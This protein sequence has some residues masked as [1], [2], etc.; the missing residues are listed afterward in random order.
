MWGNCSVSW[1]WKV[2]K[3]EKR[4]LMIQDME[5]EHTSQGGEWV[6]SVTAITAITPPRGRMGYICHGYHGYHGYHTSQGE[7]VLGC[8]V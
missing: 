3:W 4:R 8:E 6:I 5:A 7:Y 1:V 2:V